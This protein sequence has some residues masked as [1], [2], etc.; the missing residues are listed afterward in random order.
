[1]TGELAT[2]TSPVTSVNQS[3]C[4]AD[5]SSIPIRSQGDA[6]LSSDITLSSVYHDLSSKKI[7]G[8]G[9][10]RD[11]L[12]YFGDPLPSLGYYKARLLSIS[13]SLLVPYF[14]LFLAS[15]GAHV[16]FKIEAPPVPNLMI[17]LYVVSFSGIPRC[18]KGYRCYDPVTRHMYHSLDVTFLET[19]PFFSD[20]TPSPDPG[21][22]ILAADGPIPPRPLPILEPPSSPP[23]PN[24]SLPPFASQ[25]P[26]PRAQ[27]PLPVS[28]PESGMSPPLV[29]DIPP[30]RYPTR[31]RRPPSRF[32]FFNSIEH[33]IA[34]YMSYHG[35]SDS[36]KSFLSQVD[37]ISIPRSVHEA[38]QNP[39]WVSA[40]KAEMEALQHNRTWDLVAL[41]KGECTVGC[42]GCSV[43]SIW[44]M[45]R[46]I[47]IRLA[48]LLRVLLRFRNAFLN[49]DLSET[50]YMD[51]PPGFR[52]QGEYSGNVCRLRKSIYGLKQSPRAWFYRFSEV[53]M[54]MDFQQCH[55]D[56]TCFIRRQSQGRCIIISVYVDDIIITGDDASGIVQVKCGLKKAFDIKDLG[57]LRYF[58]GM[59][60][61]RP[62]STPMVPN[63]KISAE[64]GE[65]LPDPSIYQRLVG[66]LIYLTNTRPDLTFAVSIV[67]QFMHSPR[68]S[69]LDAVYH[70][71]R[72][73]KSC[74]GRGLFY[75]SGVQSGLSCFTDADYAG[76]KSD[77]R[78]TSGFC[79]FHGSHLISWKSK[80]QAV[81]SRSSAEAEY[82]A[83]AQG[84]SEIL[85]LRSLLTELGFSMTDS[86]Y[87]F[88]DNK[89]AIMLSSDSVLHERTKHI[90]VD[91]HFIREKVRSGVIT[92][93]FVPSYAQTADMFTKS[94]GPSLLKSSLVKLGLVDIFA[95]A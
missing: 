13:F 32:L 47:D 81:V 23:T 82:R 18:P 59:L 63:L 74:P 29:S 79:T 24:G 15:L 53:V 1:M 92:P 57:P 45:A 39:L 51:P 75:K 54:S 49:G 6:R 2:F 33:P 76:S 77:R 72:Y 71:L 12:Y 35:L 88:C 84:T 87:L 91:I 58:L 90:E 66:R 27:T 28:S 30:P 37:S 68:T 20:S 4:I 83:M 65:L 56:H 17:R 11:G 62:A 64:S 55:S 70:I 3:V 25:D 34:Q 73:L 67:S 60:G 61:C 31:V 93:S 10:E 7:F 50:I 19:V 52:A 36:Y 44:Q 26:S 46:L 21:S 86:S 69:H 95:S 80:K 89:S 38:L 41:P 22:E 9:Y 42:N 94:I 43:S 40:M 85:W 5:G 78:S 8:R 48:L 14:L 16:L